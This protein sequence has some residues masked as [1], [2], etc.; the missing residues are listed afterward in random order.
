MAVLL[1]VGSHAFAQ[2]AADYVKEFFSDYL[3]LASPE[4]SPKSLRKA[5]VDEN[6]LGT[7]EKQEQEGDFDFI[8]NGQDAQLDADSTL[9]I[10]PLKNRWYDVSYMDTYNHKRWHSL[11]RLTSRNGQTKIDNVIPVI[12]QPLAKLT[13]KLKASEKGQ[14]YNAADDIAFLTDFYHRYHRWIALPNLDLL[15]RAIRYCPSMDKLNQYVV[16]MDAVPADAYRTV[17]AAAASNNVVRVTFKANGKQHARKVI[18]GEQNGKRVIENILPTDANAQVF[19][20]K[21]YQISE[22]RYL[23]LNSDPENKTLGYYY[24]MTDDFDEAREGYRP[25]FFVA[26]LDRASVNREG[27]T[28]TVTVNGANLFASAVPLNIRTSYEAAQVLKP[29]SVLP[30]FINTFTMKGTFK[31]GNIV[32]FDENSTLKQVFEPVTDPHIIQAVADAFESTKQITTCDTVYAKADIQPK[33]ATAE[34]SF[35]NYIVMNTPLKLLKGAGKSKLD[36]KFIVRNDGS[37]D[38]IKVKA[39]TQE[40]ADRVAR[41][42]RFSPAWAPGQLESTDVPNC[43]TSPTY[44]VC[45]QMSYV[46]NLN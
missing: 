22:D 46:M 4:N 43:A 38:D 21:G 14:T 33:F 30:P 36:I 32:I 39:S 10:A 19:V 45:T 12:D 17:S 27:I 42:V 6:Y 13:K 18:V 41:A 16:G 44:P 28:W 5:Y 11:L 3:L 8:I 35:Q 23:I 2:S 40:L 24:G 37:I 15:V 31:D 26:P 34:Y 1:A 29:W 25:G 9:Q 7:L 20:C